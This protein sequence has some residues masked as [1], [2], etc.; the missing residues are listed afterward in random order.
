M[1]FRNEGY[2][3]GIHGEG[4]TFTCFFCLLMWD[5]IF[6]NGIDDVFRTPYQVR[7]YSKLANNLSCISIINVCKM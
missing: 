4:G 3:E 2:D 5:I 7:K 1:L 6:M